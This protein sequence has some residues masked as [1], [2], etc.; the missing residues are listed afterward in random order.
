MA[1]LK[2][3]QLQ[4]NIIH[5]KNYEDELAYIFNVYKDDITLMQA[6]T[7]ALS[8]STMFQGSNCTNLRYI[9]ALRIFAPV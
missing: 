7:E 1:Y 9:R 5:E 3:K 6:P 2:M 4:L 8:M